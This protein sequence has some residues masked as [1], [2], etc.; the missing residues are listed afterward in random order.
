MK[1]SLKIITAFL[2][3]VLV[4]VVIGCGRLALWSVKAMF[5]LL[6][7]AVVFSVIVLFLH[8]I[9]YVLEETNEYPTIQFLIEA[10]LRDL[11]D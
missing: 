10:F 1:Y 11:E 7:L 8:A 9:V 5:W 4:Q 6:T 2:L 3:L